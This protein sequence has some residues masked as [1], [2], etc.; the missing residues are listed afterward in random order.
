MTL[1]RQTSEHPFCAIKGWMGRHF[2]M[3]TLPK[4]SMELAL[5]VLA[6]R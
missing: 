4:V 3:R 5:N 2:Q 6:H 1:R